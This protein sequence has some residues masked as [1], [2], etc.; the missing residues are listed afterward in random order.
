M[1]LPEITASHW[2]LSP[3][4]DSLN[5]KRLRGYV[6]AA[7]LQVLGALHV[8]GRG[9]CFDINEQ[10]S[11]V[12]VSI[13]QQF[14]H[15]FCEKF[16][17]ELYT[18]WIH[19][20][21]G[22]D[23]KRVMDQYDKLGFTGA[24]GSMDV[25]H[26]HWG[27]TTASHTPLFKGKEK[28]PTIAYEAIVDHAGRV[29]ACTRGYPGAQN[30]KTIVRLDAAVT[31]IRTAERYTGVVYHLLRDDGTQT[32]KE[33]RCT[34]AFLLVDGGYHMVRGSLLGFVSLNECRN[35]NPKAYPK[36]TKRKHSAG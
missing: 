4:L 19:L 32:G 5:A 3:V 7:R 36:R 13:S 9:N 20:P 25:T 16:V 33:T 15:E 10:C 1:S 8:L 35:G 6:D 24:M 14:F 34:G 11:S 30:D 29:M 26:V 23:L 18:T 27:R 17:H 2:R 31:T 22:D 21:E 12:S 28:F